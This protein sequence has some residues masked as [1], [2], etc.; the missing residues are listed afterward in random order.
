MQNASNFPR[1]ETSRLILRAIAPADAEAYRKLLS[2]ETA[3]PYITDS[4]PISAAQIHDRIC[5]NQAL[6]VQGSAIYWALE[7]AERFV[8][9]VALHDRN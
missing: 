2:D 9:Y 8:G 5:R 3:Y 1:L 7:Y 4:G 6:F